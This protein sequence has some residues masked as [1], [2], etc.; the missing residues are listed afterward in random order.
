MSEYIQMTPFIS[1]FL[2][3]MIL[4]C[5]LWFHDVWS[6]PEGRAEKKKW[7]Y[8]PARVSGGNKHNSQLVALLQP[9]NPGKESRRAFLVRSPAQHGRRP[10]LGQRQPRHS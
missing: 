5:E 3:A 6:P 1:P 4:L 8:S 2:L 10:H 7:N 9:S